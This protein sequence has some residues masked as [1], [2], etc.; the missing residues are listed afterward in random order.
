MTL[1]GV[2]AALSPAMANAVVGAGQHFGIAFVVLAAT[3]VLALPIFRLAQRGAAS[4]A[5][6]A[7]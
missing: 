2:G 6:S 3:S 7:R 1:Q 4:P 5:G